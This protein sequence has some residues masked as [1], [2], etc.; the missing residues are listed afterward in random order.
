MATVLARQ[1]TRRHMPPEIEMN[2][3]GTLLNSLSLAVGSS[4][5]AL[6]TLGA[7]FVVTARFIEAVLPTLTTGQ[8]LETIQRFRNGVEDAMAMADDLYLPARY[9][10]A[11]LEQ[12][13]TLLGVLSEP[14]PPRPSRDF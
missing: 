9:H 8:R 14:V 1:E 11:F 2:D 3:A 12:V 4:T 7:K 10:E 5:E 13:N 6:A